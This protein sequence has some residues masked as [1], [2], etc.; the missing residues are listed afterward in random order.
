VFKK[1][2]SKEGMHLT[3]LLNHHYNNSFKLVDMRRVDG[4]CLCNKI[5]SFAL[6]TLVWK[7]GKLVQNLLLEI[8]SR[9]P[10]HIITVGSM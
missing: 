10:T 9:S 1:L 7:F 3:M 6:T 2:T 4:C 8:Q 5:G